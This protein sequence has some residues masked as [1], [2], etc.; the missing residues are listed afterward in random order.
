MEQAR[1]LELQVQGNKSKL[2]AEKKLR[3]EQEL[4]EEDRL[5]RERQEIQAVY[6]QEVLAVKVSVAICRT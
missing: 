3:E 4:R 2:L 6:E 1:A 5:T